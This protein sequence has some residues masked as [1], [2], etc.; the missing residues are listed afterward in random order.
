MPI[1]GTG[2]FRRALKRFRERQAE[3]CAE[4]PR[5]AKGKATSSVLTEPQARA[6]KSLHGASDYNLQT[7]VDA[8]KHLIVH[9]EVCYATSDVP[10]LLP[11]AQGV[12]QRCPPPGLKS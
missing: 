9:H 8:D 5:L 1:S 4:V 2:A 3:V 12:T 11:M 10:Q 7:A 6:I